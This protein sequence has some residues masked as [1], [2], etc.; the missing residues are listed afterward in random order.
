MAHGGEGDSPPER[1]HSTGLLEDVEQATSFAGFTADRFRRAA[2]VDRHFSAD[3]AGNPTGDV[4]GHR[5]R[6]ASGPS[7]VSAALNFATDRVG[8]FLR[9]SFFDHR[10]R[11]NG[12][13]LGSALFHV[14][15]SRVRNSF[16]HTLFYPSA[17]ANGN[18]LRAAL[19]GVADRGV[20]HAFA[21]LLFDVA[22]RRVADPTGAA[23]R[24]SLA[25]GVRNTFTFD[26]LAVSCGADF[27]LN[28]F[29]APDAS[30]NRLRAAST[31]WTAVGRTG[32]VSTRNTATWHACADRNLFGHGLPFAALHIH[33]VPFLNRFANRVANIAVPSFRHGFVGGARHGLVALVVDG[34]ADR[35]AHRTVVTFVDRLA[36]FV[37]DR[38]VTRFPNRLTN[39]A[40]DGLVA[41]RVDR[42]A[43]GVV[44]RLVAGVDLGNASGVA[45]VP[46]T[47]LVDIL[48]GLARNLLDDGVVDRLRALLDL[49]VVN[50]FFDG[51]VLRSTA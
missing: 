7:L 4:V 34:L 31:R 46:V 36:N 50:G 38:L 8:H 21:D 29:R 35:I 5:A 25:N 11:A 10:A 13:R 32:V 40:R 43:S 9:A 3:G 17:G 1:L 28:R 6:H 15:A 30:T 27:L 24:D 14:S 2:G 20:R 26:F 47:G 19:L 42:L 23:L 16:L 18:L 22:N 39:L 33:R 49:A 37:V 51:F 12:N 48:D 41:C 44:D 45:D